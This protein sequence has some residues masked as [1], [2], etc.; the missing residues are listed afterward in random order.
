MV[1]T[2]PKRVATNSLNNSTTSRNGAS[3]D[4]APASSNSLSPI[5]PGRS[6][7]DAFP[8]CPGDLDLTRPIEYPREIDL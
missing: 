6:L 7:K 3:S 4:G 5:P 1:R 8:T 2:F